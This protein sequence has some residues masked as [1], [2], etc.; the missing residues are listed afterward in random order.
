[1]YFLSYIYFSQIINIFIKNKIEYILIPKYKN[2]RSPNNKSQF[3]QI[4]DA[5]LLTRRTQ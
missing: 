4:N 2:K 5:V 3:Y 1:M